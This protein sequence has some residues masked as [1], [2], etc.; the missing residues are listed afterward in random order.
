MANAN[1]EVT[2]MTRTKEKILFETNELV[3]SLNT[4][5][6]VLTNSNNELKKTIEGYMEKM[7]RQLDKMDERDA[8]LDQRVTI[9]RSDLNNVIE[10][11]KDLKADQSVVKWLNF[12]VTSIVSV[13]S[14]SIAYYL[15]QR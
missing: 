4:Q 9:L 10:D 12:A 15:G 6:A 8:I 2:T 11:V 14:A 3:I 1:E 13:I 7:D 5:V